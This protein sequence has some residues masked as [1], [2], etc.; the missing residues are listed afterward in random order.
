MPCS[1]VMVTVSPALRL[2]HPYAA[3]TGAHW[4]RSAQ[5]HRWYCMLPPPPPYGLACGLRVCAGQ[6][7][8]YSRPCSERRGRVQ[9]VVA[10]GRSK[11]TTGT[12][13]MNEH[14]SRSHE[15]VTLRITYSD[16]V[17]DVVSRL[18]LLDLAG[19]E[20]VGRSGAAGNVLK[21]A[22]SIN[23]SLSALGDVIAALQSGLPHIPYRNSKLTQVLQDS[24]QGGSKVRRA[25]V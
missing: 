21:E 11:R 19:S 17:R 25:P 2:P 1:H 8:P 5:E 12:T 4:R 15:L 7:R 10:S 24:L 23:K 22:Q 9:E 6:L 20:R 16:G 3:C 14:S 13:D 18:N